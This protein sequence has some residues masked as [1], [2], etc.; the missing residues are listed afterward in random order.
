M[1]AQLYYFSTNV[2]AGQ[3]RPYTVAGTGASGSLNQ[4]TTATDLI[5]TTDYIE[6]RLK[7]ILADGS[8]KTGITKRDVQNFLELAHRWLL[9]Q[10]G[11][12]ASSS[13][14]NGQ[15]LDYCIKANS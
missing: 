6:L 13:G 12:A 1:A 4:G 7:T 11:L 5:N 10:T 2:P 3:D 15:G 8:T 9:D 14:A